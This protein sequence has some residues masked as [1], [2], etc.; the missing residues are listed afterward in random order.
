MLL[1]DFLQWFLRQFARNDLT[2]R[3]LVHQSLYVNVAYVVVLLSAVSQDCFFSTTPLVVAMVKLALINNVQEIRIA[4]IK[5]I[6][7]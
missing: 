7:E 2:C 4:S 6:A 3:L 5:L 1:E